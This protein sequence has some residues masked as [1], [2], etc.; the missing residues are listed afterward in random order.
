LQTI[1]FKRLTSLAILL[2]VTS[3]DSAR[4]ENPN[5]ILSVIGTNDVHGALL[6]VDGNQ[7]LA[8]FAGYVNNLRETRAGDGGEVLLIDAG[9]MW[10]GTIES[11]IS[12]GASVVAAFNAVAYDAAAI[13]NHEFDFGPAGEKATTTSD[14]DDAQGALKRRATEAEFPLLAA[15]LVDNTTGLPVA[16]SNVQPSV[17]INRGGLKIGIIGLMTENA[18][19]TTMASHTRGLSVAPLTSTTVQEARKL[20]QA[21][22]DL[23]IVSA[24][25]GSRCEEFDNPRD[26]SS[27]DINGEIMQLALDLPVGLVDHIIGGHTH[28]GIAHE[29][30]GIAITSNFSNTQTFGRVDFTFNRADRSLISHQIFP[31]Q[32]V[33]GYVDNTTGNCVAANDATGAAQVASYSGRI[34]TPDAQIV[35]IAAHAAQRAHVLKSEMLGVYLDTPITRQGE[36]NSALG[37]LFTDVMLD[38]VGGDV[39]VHNVTGG[40]RADL[41]Q[42]DL[43]YGSVYEM[44][45]FDNLVVRLD[46]SGAELRR[47]LEREVFRPNR[48]AGIAGI[49]V[50]AA[51]DD[52]LLS[53]TMMRPD[54]SAI[55][56]HEMLAVMTTDFLALGGDDVFTPVIPEEGFPIAG[57]T[58]L[59]RE[60]IVNWMRE[61]G[62]NLSVDSFSDTD[63]PKWNIPESVM[64]RCA[65]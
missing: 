11:N 18:L 17:L 58:R 41:P 46:L 55:E 56:D 44:Y 34:V 10:Q 20:R 52:G 64:M 53:L 25:A 37:H 4:V 1:R 21:G 27:C 7:G 2:L 48:R 13:G 9:D 28:Q 35:E 43:V 24:H 38:A 19:I 39:L 57:S 59:V 50:F 30:L 16:W 60:T 22:A 45:P 23:V 8:L 33:C 6:P 63:N 42:G 29:I 5:F 47:V 61:R 51:C 49:R 12:E 40:I 14:L 3:C 32:R 65:P 62:G 31:P 15:N 54:G 36:P 26:L